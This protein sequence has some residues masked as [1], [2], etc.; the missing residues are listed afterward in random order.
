[1]KCFC[2]R[3]IF[4]ILL[5]TCLQC[6]TVVDYKDSET[7]PITVIS[8]DTTFT[9]GNISYTG[10]LAQP[11]QAGNYPIVL[12]LHGSEGFKDH[13]K[14]YADSIAEQGYI[15]FAWCWF[16]CDSRT[17]MADVGTR[18]FNY[19]LHYLKELP[20]A[21]PDKCG[22]IGFSA[23]AAMSLYLG[24]A[25]NNLSVIVEY[26]GI[27]RIPSGATKLVSENNGTVNVN[28]SKLAPPLLIVQGTA[29]RITTMNEV[30]G[31]VEQLD[32]MDKIYDTLYCSGATHS[33]NWPDASGERGNIYD[34]NAA[35]KAL[36]E[37]ITFLSKYLK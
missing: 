4:L 21:D 2:S 30:L 34:E 28:L 36:N 37:T 7:E 1:M 8:S 5:I 27:N 6:E 13:H 23:G 31:M 16:G 33:F 12:V 18:D 9:I 3:I 32:N 26:Y 10:H 14:A 15:A 19:V 20:D 25:I 22:I 11:D 35:D 17:S 29:D 24:T